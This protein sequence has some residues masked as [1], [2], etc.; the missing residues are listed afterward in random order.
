MRLNVLAETSDRAEH[1]AALVAG[2][3]AQVHVNVVEAGLVEIERAIAKAADEFA[4]A[5][6]H[7]AGERFA[8]FERHGR[9]VAVRVASFGLGEIGRRRFAV[10]LQLRACN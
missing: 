6:Y 9:H 7:P 1:P 8:V 3:V 2:R 4:V 10:R 5:P